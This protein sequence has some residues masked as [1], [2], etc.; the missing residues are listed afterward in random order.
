[1]TQIL[2][3]LSFSVEVHASVNH[4]ISDFDLARMPGSADS[5]PTPEG[6][7]YQTEEA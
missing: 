4:R 2:R 5:S 3:V 6:G 7:A 1:L